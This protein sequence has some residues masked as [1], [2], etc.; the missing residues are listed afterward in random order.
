[1]KFLVPFLVEIEPPIDETAFTDVIP[2]CLT[3]SASSLVI[4]ERWIIWE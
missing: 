1:M 2:G 4:V 3:A